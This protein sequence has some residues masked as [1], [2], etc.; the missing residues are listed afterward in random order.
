MHN[1]AVFR[2]TSPEVIEAHR[3]NVARGR[4]ATAKWRRFMDETGLKPVIIFHPQGAIVPGVY[5]SLEVDAHN[6]PPGWFWDSARGLLA[7]APGHAGEPHAAGRAALEQLADMEWAL[8]PLPGIDRLSS[9]HSITCLD[10][11][12]EVA[13][14]EAIAVARRGDS[15]SMEINDEVWLILPQDAA[16][17]IDDGQWERSRRYLLEDALFT[18]TPAL[19][20]LLT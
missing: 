10:C 7:P 6:P 4:V 1:P 12:D 3:E 15:A 17:A 14:L 16:S 13:R 8:D 5:P 19:E 9:M 11:E 2:S 20:A 18:Q